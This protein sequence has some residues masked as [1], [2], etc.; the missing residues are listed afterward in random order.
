MRYRTLGGGTLGGVG[1]NGVGAGTQVNMT[2]SRS[3]RGRTSCRVPEHGS[4]GGG[5]RGAKMQSALWPLLTCQHI[6]IYIQ[7]EQ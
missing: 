5:V 2:V 6:C 7:R 1:S 4:Q 3:E